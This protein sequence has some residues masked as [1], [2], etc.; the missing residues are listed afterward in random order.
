MHTELT[1]DAAK[2]SD[3][4]AYTSGGMEPGSFGSS[5][6]NPSVFF[7]ER[8]LELSL[9]EGLFSVT[10]S[11]FALSA[12]GSDFSSLGKKSTNGQT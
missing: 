5:K 11:L 2:L 1:W 6:V 10:L 3:E 7:S 12:F 8:V 4:D 9:E